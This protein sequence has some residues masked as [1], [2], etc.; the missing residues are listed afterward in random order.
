MS[1][2]ALSQAVINRKY[3]T[4]EAKTKEPTSSQA[5]L[6]SFNMSIREMR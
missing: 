3:S 4:P 6:R 2:K 1:R 5:F